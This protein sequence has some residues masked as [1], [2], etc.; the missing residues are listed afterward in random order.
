M[1]AELR[2]RLVVALSCHRSNEKALLLVTWNVDIC[3]CNHV[4]LLQWWVSTGNKSLEVGLEPCSGFGS[5]LGG[6]G[7]TAVG[8]VSW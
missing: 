3:S 5:G 6:I 1:R 7:K 8:V 4:Q 2:V